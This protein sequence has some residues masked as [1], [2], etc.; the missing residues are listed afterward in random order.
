MVRYP[1]NAATEN[2]PVTLTALVRETK[3]RA[4]KCAEGGEISLHLSHHEYIVISYFVHATIMFVLVL[5]L[6]CLTT[7]LFFTSGPGD[8]LLL[9][10]WDG[11]LVK[12]ARAS[13]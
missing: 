13:A 4:P 10:P 7:L 11:G 8:C 12:P 2:R 5:N 9:S 6:L 3:R 1:L